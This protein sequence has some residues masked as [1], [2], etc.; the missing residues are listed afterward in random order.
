MY[1]LGTDA[2]V[3]MWRSNNSTKQ[4]ALLPCLPWG[5]NAGC[6]AWPQVFDPTGPSLTYSKF[7]TWHLSYSGYLT[8][9]R[10]YYSLDTNNLSFDYLP[11]VGLKSDERTENRISN[12][13]LSVSAL[14]GG[15]PGSKVRS[16]MKTCFFCCCCLFYF[17]VLGTEPKAS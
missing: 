6:Q 13:Q 3:F 2:T 14:G 4:S 16:H 12:S 11:S 1:V 7:F 5:L 9:T 17:V 8:K 10:N 15:L